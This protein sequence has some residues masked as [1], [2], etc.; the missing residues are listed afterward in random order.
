ME[1]NALVSDSKLVNAINYM[2]YSNSFRARDWLKRSINNGQLDKFQLSLKGNP[3]NFPFDDGDGEFNAHAIVSNMNLNFSDNYPF[4]AD[5]NSNIQF[6]G[7]EMLMK[8]DSGKIINAEI[9]HA[10]A[11]IPN[12]YLREKLLTISGNINGSTQDLISFIDGSPLNRNT[13]LSNVNNTLLPVGELQLELDMNVP[14][15][16]PTQTLTLNGAMALT[17]AAIQSNEVNLSLS[18]IGGNLEFTESSLH[19]DALNAIYDAT[20][21]KLSIQGSKYFEKI[22]L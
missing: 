3:K 11:H 14:I 21:V 7:H 16:M 1:I 22:L 18:E 8:I 15:R 17:N 5:I 13:M 10:T 4:I 12:L 2:P 20:P 9:N 19:A 6:S